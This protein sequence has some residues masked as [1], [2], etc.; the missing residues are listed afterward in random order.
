[1]FRVDGKMVIASR[2]SWMLRNGEI[3]YNE[4]F[5]GICVLHKCDNRTCVN[6]EHLFI[7]TN[8]ENMKDRD[9][10]GRKACGELQGQ[11]K[12]T[13]E[14]ILEIRE[15]GKKGCSYARIAALP[16]IGVSQPAVCNIINRKRWQHIPES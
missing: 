10:K 6:P 16:H 2:I 4:S 3:P 9:S 14:K 11:S 5:H 1:M 15:L 7:G 12:L 13:T 8:T